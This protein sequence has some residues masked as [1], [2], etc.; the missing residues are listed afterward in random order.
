MQQD[1][2]TIEKEKPAVTDALVTA[3]NAA[4]PDE[5]AQRRGWFWFK[6]K[7][8]L[9]IAAVVVAANFERWTESPGDRA[10]KRQMM[11]DRL[12]N[13]S[14]NDA[15]DA[16]NAESETSQRECE[17]AGRRAEELAKSKSNWMHGQR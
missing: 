16:C 13:I 12:G 17:E 14:R 5:D 11:A 3:V 2:T 15:I 6:V 4:E 9:V 1:D 10:Y 7:A 8:F